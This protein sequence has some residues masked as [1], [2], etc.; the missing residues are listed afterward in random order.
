VFRTPAN[1]AKGVCLNP[2]SQ[3]FTAAIVE[4][5]EQALKKIATMP[6]QVATS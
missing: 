5:L 2:Q 4:L 1:K 3:A 6:Q